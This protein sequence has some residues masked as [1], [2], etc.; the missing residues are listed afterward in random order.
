MVIMLALLTWIIHRLLQYSTFPV[1]Q[2][3]LDF[4]G[5]Y[6]VHALVSIMEVVRTRQDTLVVHLQL[7]LRWT[8]S[9]AAA[10]VVE[11]RHLQ[12]LSLA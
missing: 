10:L 7:G 6:N 11:S 1:L 2:L 3:L 12:A 9:H 8:L 4:V 5:I